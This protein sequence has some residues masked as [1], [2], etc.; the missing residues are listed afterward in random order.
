MEL[1][2]FKESLANL[3]SKT[4]Q[5][6]I[7]KLF[8]G[9]IMGLLLIFAIAVFSLGLELVF[10]VNEWIQVFVHDLLGLGIIAGVLLALEVWG[11][12]PHPIEDT[13]GE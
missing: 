8:G 5:N 1:K 13:T 12:I 9:V 2:Q 11:L 10:G 7:S 6:N 3:Y 4:Q